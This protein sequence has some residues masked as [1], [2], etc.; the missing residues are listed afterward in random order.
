MDDDLQNPP[1]EIPNLINELKKGFDVVYGNPI[2]DKR[3]LMRK[4]IT[5][6]TK[7]GFP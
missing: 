4:L 6:L 7:K 5:K 3:Y 1:E 2:K